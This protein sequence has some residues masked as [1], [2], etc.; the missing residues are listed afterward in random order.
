MIVIAKTC[1]H[2]VLQPSVAPS[3]STD[4]MIER[5]KAPAA[6]TAS[7]G[8]SDGGFV[9]IGAGAAPA[10]APAVSLAAEGFFCMF[11]CLLFVTAIP[12]HDT[13]STLKWW[14]V[15]ASML[16]DAG[17]HLIYMFVHKYIYPCIYIYINAFT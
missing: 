7:A 3:I 4:G 2:P 6:L 12:M 5:D 15:T 11:I 9:G 10:T 14:A 13:K 16:L 17:R 1:T 8:F